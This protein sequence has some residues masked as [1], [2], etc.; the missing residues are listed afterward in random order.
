MVLKLEELLIKSQALKH[1]LAR[2]KRVKLVR[3]ELNKARKSLPA[4]TDTDHTSQSDGDGENDST[5][6]KNSS[7]NSGAG[8]LENS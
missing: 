7:S 6:V 5:D 2:A 8:I 4:H 1:G 3:S